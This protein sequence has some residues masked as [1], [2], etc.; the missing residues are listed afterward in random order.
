MPRAGLIA[1]P[2]EPFSG[3]AITNAEGTRETLL[4]QTEAGS[5]AS[6]VVFRGKVYQL[7]R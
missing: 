6:I 5:T 2:G 1:L 3:N 7:P 4:Y